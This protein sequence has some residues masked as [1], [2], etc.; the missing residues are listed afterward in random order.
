MRPS[1]DPFRRKDARDEADRLLQPLVGTTSTPT[2]PAVAEFRYAAVA[3]RQRCHGSEQCK[4]PD[5]DEGRIG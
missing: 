1:L 5:I 4:A 3:A 2:D